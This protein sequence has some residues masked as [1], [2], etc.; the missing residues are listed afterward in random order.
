MA[1][2]AEKR[3]S[4]RSCLVCGA[5]RRKEDLVRF[6]VA[7]GRSTPDWRG[8]LPG[9]AVY[10]CPTPA[11][12]DRF[13]RLKRFPDRFLKGAPVFA[14]P[15]EDMMTWVRERAEESL[16]H[17]LCLARKSGTLTPGQDAARAVASPAALLISEDAAERTVCAVTRDLPDG[18][19]VIRWG[20]KERLGAALGLRPLGVAALAAS[21]LTERIVHYASIANLFGQES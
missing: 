8:V 1:R 18:A 9:R 6:V 13:W 21:P 11:C 16:L 19:V 5:E 12:L 10:A 3:N 14:V 7:A 20:T 4:V 15:R 17:F 2:T